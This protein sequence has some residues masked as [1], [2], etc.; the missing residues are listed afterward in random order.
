MISGKE[1][2]EKNF[3]QIEET[4]EK[5]FSTGNEELDNLLTEVYYSGIEDGYDYAQKEFADK[6]DKSG[7]KTA[8][9]VALGTGAA[10]ALTGG[11]A[12]N[13]IADKVVKKAAK[14]VGADKVG[15]GAGSILT[16]WGPRAQEDVNHGTELIKRTLNS[17]KKF[18]LAKKADIGGTAVMAAGG[19]LL[20]AN[21][22]KKKKKE[23][24]K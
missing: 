4:E 11:I 20:A 9:K 24:K 16:K 10:A 3:S 19:A 1:F 7:L 6:E 17:N 14:K 13:V 22:I 5:L 12:E 2:A 15:F 18:K 21:A 23:E 8:G